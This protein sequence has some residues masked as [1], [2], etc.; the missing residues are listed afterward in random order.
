SAEHNDPR[1]DIDY[2]RASVTT[3]A[4]RLQEHIGE[5]EGRIARLTESTRSLE[6]G[7]DKRLSELCSNI[8]KDARSRLESITS[9]ILEELTARGSKISG[10]QL[11]KSNENMALVQKNIIASASELI[12]AEAKSALQAFKQSMDEHTNISL[13]RWRRELGDG[14]NALASSLSPKFQ[15]AAA[16][17]TEGNQPQ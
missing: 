16:R 4:W 12:N 13:D 14:L 6:S 7:L 2:F 3:D 9:E 5:L 10:D 8:L 17:G 11:D 15:S 1:G